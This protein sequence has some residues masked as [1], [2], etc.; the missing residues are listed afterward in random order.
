MYAH[1]SEKELEEKLSSKVHE[2]IGRNLI[3]KQC[4]FMRMIYIDSKSQPD[5][6]N[7]ITLRNYG[8]FKKK[9]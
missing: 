6:K 1:I 2:H 8:N 7:T 5:L 9:D 4:L 3:K